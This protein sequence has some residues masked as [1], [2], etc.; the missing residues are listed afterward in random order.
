MKDF[1]WIYLSYLL[2]D[3]ISAYGDGKRI[4]VETTKSV[5]KEYT[6]NG[7]FLNLP[8]HFGTHIDFP[9]HF[10]ADGKKGRF[11]PSRVFHIQ[12]HRLHFYKIK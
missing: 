6:C 9:Y 4:K 7:S 3:K 2:S 12:V 8:T 10:D 1:S 5:R 11:L